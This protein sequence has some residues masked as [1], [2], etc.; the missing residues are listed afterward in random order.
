MVSSRVAALGARVRRTGAAG[1][2]PGPGADGRRAASSPL[3]RTTDPTQIEDK[4]QHGTWRGRLASR[5]G[6]LGTSMASS[7]DTSGAPPGGGE[8]DRSHR[9]ERIALVLGAACGLA[10]A[11]YLA[12]VQVGAVAQPWDPL[13]GAASSLRVL[14]SSFSRALPIPDA[15]LGA[16]AYA[17][18]GILAAWGGTRRWRTRPWLAVCSGFVAGA[19]GLVGVLLVLLQAFVLRAGCALCLGS[20]AL[21]I[22]MAVVASEELRA[23]ASVLR[24]GRLEREHA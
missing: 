8:P 22:S 24:H 21:S 14:H 15:A 4:E 20:A 12:L 13:F 2:R 1:G 7:T 9:G 17:A 5:P 16:V 10:I 11:T 23:A 19:L 18:E 6:P 3:H